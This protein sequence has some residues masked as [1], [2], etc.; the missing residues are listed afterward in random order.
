GETEQQLADARRELVRIGLDR[1]AGAA[2]GG[3][4]QLAAG[5]ELGSYPVSDFPGLTAALAADPDLVV[6][7]ARRDDERAGGGVRGSVHIPIHDLADRLEEVPAGDVWVYCGSGY[8]ASI[9][10]SLLAR[11][12]R[13]PVLVDGGYH[14]PDTGAAA[15]GLHTRPATA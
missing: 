12:G 3:P 6:L 7:D 15:V 14:D 11:A 1:L 2:I 5:R 4:E 10:A 13:R 9:A 8:R